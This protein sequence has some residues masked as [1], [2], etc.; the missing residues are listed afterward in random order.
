MKRTTDVIFVSV[1]ECDKEGC[2]AKVEIE[3]PKRERYTH[4][5]LNWQY[6]V[7]CTEDEIQYHTYCPDHH[8]PHK[9]GT[10]TD[11]YAK[12]VALE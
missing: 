11:Q 3:E 2:E 1:I 6:I 4:V 10:D 9:H 5:P 8:V 7:T 12:E